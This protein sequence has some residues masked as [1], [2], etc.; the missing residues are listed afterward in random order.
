MDIDKATADFKKALAKSKAEIEAKHK[1]SLAKF[2][3]EKQSLLSDIKRLQAQVKLEKQKADETIS[4][5]NKQT[6]VD[7]EKLARIK[8]DTKVAHGEYHSAV[9]ALRHINEKIDSKQTEA[10][11]LTLTCKTTAAVLNDLTTQIEQKNIALDKIAKRNADEVVQQ[12]NALG[13]VQNDKLELTQ[14]V[15]DL[16]EELRTQQS[17]NEIEL[18]NIQGTIVDAKRE[19]D[20]V[21]SQI[22]EINKEIMVAAGE[23]DKVEKEV[24]DFNLYMTNERQKI[25]VREDI[26]LHNEQELA[27]YK[28]AKESRDSVLRG[29]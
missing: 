19:L 16:K 17:T 29:L 23:R 3:I 5:I 2:K 20:S 18:K 14:T 8:E 9:M 6:E 26:L 27:D 25:K 7:N 11:E 28:R 24:E 12:R 10:D 13:L 21:Q 15:A 4:N 1:Q 22:A